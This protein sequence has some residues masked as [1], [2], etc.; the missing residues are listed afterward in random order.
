M[1]GV[2]VLNFGCLIRIWIYEGPRKETQHP[3]EGRRIE[4]SLLGVN[5]KGKVG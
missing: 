4:R 2:G 5:Y 3:E 1:G